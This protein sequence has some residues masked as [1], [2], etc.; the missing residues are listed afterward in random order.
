MKPP[1]LLEP[2]PPRLVWVRATDRYPDADPKNSFIAMDGEVEV[3][4]VKLVAIGPDE[5]R[6]LWS[7]LFT[8][9]GPLS[10]SRPT[11]R[12]RRAGRPRANSTPA[13]GR[14]ERGSG[15]NDERARSIS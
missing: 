10:G 13:G 5:G 7:M 11:A 15:S 12:A 8:H 4:V 2:D 3:G 6:W 1:R 9:P 14:S